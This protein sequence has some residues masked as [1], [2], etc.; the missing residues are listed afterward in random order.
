MAAISA[1]DRTLKEYSDEL[2]QEPEE[3]NATG[4]NPQ[5]RL[6]VLAGAPIAAGRPDEQ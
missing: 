2:G 3:G 4:G 6:D 5:K 1:D